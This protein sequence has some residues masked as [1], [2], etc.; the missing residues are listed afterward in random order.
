M[1]GPRMLFV[2]NDAAF[3]LSHRMPIALAARDAGFDVH[4]AT[5]PSPAVQE[6]EGLGFRHHSLKISRGGA[7]P[8]VELGSL[9]QMVRLFRTLRPTLVHLVTPKPVVYGGIAAR[10]TRIR[11]VVAAISGLGFVFALTG[12]RSRFM[13][14]LVL[15]LYRFA[16]T[17][18]NV[19]VI[20]QNP[21]DRELLLR[22][23][24]INRESTVLIRGSGVQLREYRFVPEPEGRP[25]VTMVSRL[26]RDKG[27]YEFVEAAGLLAREGM[28]VRAL[29]VGK[30]DMANPASITMAEVERWREAGVVEP[31]GFRSDV[32]DIFAASNVV[33]FPSYYGEGLPKVLVEAAACGRAVV[34]TDVPGCRDAIEAGVTGVL[35]PARDAVAVANAIRALILDPS[36]RRQMGAAGRALA[37]RAY[38]IERVVAAHLS[39]Y[40]DVLAMH[41][42]SPVRT[43]PC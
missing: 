14:W 5:P 33:V 8:W 29:L 16:L 21:D 43:P 6:V 3:F 13:R 27:V 4:I 38:G 19:R 32:A 37:E 7:N 12:G 22:T 20:F 31:L 40:E 34:T 23:G 17:H 42:I 15:L 28:A 18:R 25:V 10:I 30:P 35:V 26:L 36:L 24:G 9:W 2:V 11:A 41:Q 1:V 39:L